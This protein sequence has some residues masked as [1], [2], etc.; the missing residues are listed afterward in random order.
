MVK[1]YTLLLLSALLVSSMSAPAPDTDTGGIINPRLN[2]ISKRNF[3][4]P[5]IKKFSNFLEDLPLDQLT[6]LE[7]AKDISEFQGILGALIHDDNKDGENVF[8]MID[9]LK[10]RYTMLHGIVRGLIAKTGKSNPVSGN[11]PSSQN[12]RLH[13]VSRTEEPSKEPSSQS[14]GQSPSKL[15]GAVEKIVEQQLMAAMKTLPVEDVEKL[16]N[17]LAEGNDPSQILKGLQ[18]AFPKLTDELIKVAVKYSSELKAVIDQITFEDKLEAAAATAQPSELYEAEKE[19]FVM[20]EEVEKPTNSGSPQEET[21]NYGDHEPRPWN[22]GYIYNEEEDVKADEVSTDYYRPEQLNVEKEDVMVVEDE[23]QDYFSEPT[24][25]P[26]STNLEKLPKMAGPNLL[27]EGQSHS[28]EI[29]KPIH[30]FGRIFDA[31]TLGDLKLLEHTIGDKKDFSE[32]EGLLGALADDGGEDVYSMLDQLKGHYTLLHGI[33]RGMI[34]R[35]EKLNPVT[36][37]PGT[38][39]P[40]KEP[41]SQS[42]GQSSS[43]YPVKP[44][45]DGA[46]EKIVEQPSQSNGQSSSQNEVKSQ[47]DGAIEKI[48]EQQLMAAMKPLPV[49]DLKKLQ[50]MLAEGNDPSLILKGLQPA[51]P[52]LTDDLIKVA[53]K[54]SSELK[55]VIDQITF[56]DKLEAAAATAQPSELYEAEKEDFDVMEEE[57]EEVEKPTNSGSPQEETT[58][59]GDHE[60][61]PWNNGYIYKEKED[62]MADKESTDYYR[63][64]QVNEEEENVMVVEDEA[65]DHYL[66]QWPTNYDSRPEQEPAGSGWRHGSWH[67]FMIFLVITTLL[68]VGFFCC[69]SKDQ[70]RGH[71]KASIPNSTDSKEQT[72]HIYK[73]KPLKSISSII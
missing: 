25:S 24:A 9:Q 18:P 61:R 69:Q 20:E 2:P 8:D 22:N 63:P 51:F 13:P 35:K 42:N 53:V 68:G 71:E 19:D 30:K 70:V 15:D 57:A 28:G 4:Q 56:E 48:V 33:L 49:E 67:C 50:N 38:K 7:S 23:A 10:N 64:E 21:T 44:K 17:M 59:Y 16:Q 40:S 29:G 62:V 58:N 45:L 54:Y 1:C 72:L 34:S 43:Q 31:M 32:F 52:K 37:S 36:K 39:E 55:A 47:L 6:L 46:I 73:Y 14:N 5:L 60:P 27:T 11:E 3:V 41:P 66:L 12:E 65:Q 26:K